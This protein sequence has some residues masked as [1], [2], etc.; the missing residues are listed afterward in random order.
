ML[1]PEISVCLRIPDCIHTLFVQIAHIA[2]IGDP[3]PATGY[4]IAGSIDKNP[5]PGPGAETIP[6][7]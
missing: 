5:H 3:Y 6:A 7:V 1:P 2:D 4:D